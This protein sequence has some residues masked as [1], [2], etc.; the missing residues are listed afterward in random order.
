MTTAAGTLEERT[1]SAPVRV[2]AV[3]GALYPKGR[4]MRPR[5]SSL[6]IRT[7]LSLILSSVANAAGEATQSPGATAI[8]RT[9]DGKPDLSGIWQGMNTAAW[10]NQDHS[11]PKGGPGGQ[12]VLEGNDIP[13]QP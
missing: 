5:S 6:L 3:K 11:A 2:R 10:D 7:L 4:S 12:G 8:P 1:A 13:Y 9:P